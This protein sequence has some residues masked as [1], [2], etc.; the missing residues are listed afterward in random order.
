MAGTP[1]LLTQTPGA[2]S[3]L[4]ETHGLI[5][6]D[7]LSDILRV[8]GLTGGVFLE[9]RFTTPWCIVGK[10]G[11]EAC[12]PYMA[13]PPHVISF[14]YVVEGACA[15][16]IDGQEPATIETGEVVLLP[17]NEFHKLGNPVGAAAVPV[18]ELIQAPPALGMPRI[19]YGGGGEACSI[20]CGFLGGGVQLQPLLAG[21]PPLLTLKVND[22]PAGAWISQSFKYAA[23]ELSSGDPGA[24]TVL[25]KMS[26]LLFVEAVRRYL[27]TI[28]D[29]RTGLLAGLRDPAIGKALA[30][31]H[32]RIAR[33]WTAEDLA[34]EVNLS[35]SAFADRFTALLG[36]PPIRYLTSWRMQVAAQKL[37][38]GRLSIGQIAFDT[39]YESEAAF[40]RAFKREVGTP[41]A[42]WRKTLC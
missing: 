14:H 16:A 3:S 29:G 10:V 23:S 21:L 15:A 20:I 34:R 33:D 22:T 39:G 41:P 31:L 13:P 25:S 8:V 7:A 17:H 40:A 36:Q 19:E 12:K 11:P 24:A 1:N 30:L 27:T 6:V 32:T 18:A 37:R 26:E 9:A 42:T 4:L 2:E 38:E 28:P 5:A 35:R